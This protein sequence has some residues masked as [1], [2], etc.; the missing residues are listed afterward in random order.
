[1]KEILILEDKKPAR[2]A[3]IQIVKEVDANAVIY[4]FAGDGT[5]V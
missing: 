3:L 1:M 4:A 5:I 2:D